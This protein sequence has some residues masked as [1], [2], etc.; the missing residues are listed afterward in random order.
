MIFEKEKEKEKSNFICP[1]FLLFSFLFKKDKRKSTGA[2]LTRRDHNS[3][4]L[5]E[6]VQERPGR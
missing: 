3:T 2:I 1:M 6:A 5:L 4:C